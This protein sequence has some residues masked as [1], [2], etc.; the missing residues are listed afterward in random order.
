MDASPLHAGTVAGGRRIIDGKTQGSL[1]GPTHQRLEDNT[2]QTVAECI[3]TTAST[4]ESSV[5]ASE[6]GA[7]ARGT[8]PRCNSASPLGKEGTDE[9]QEQAWGGATVES[10]SDVGKPS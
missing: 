5:A 4:P 6:V 7:D 2:E 10:G 3:G 1:A 8:E 9:E